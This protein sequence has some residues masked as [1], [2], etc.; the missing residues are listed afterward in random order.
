MKKLPRIK[1]IVI[2]VPA[3]SELRHEA[4]PGECS[5]SDCCCSRYEVAIE[6]PEL[7]RL[8]RLVPLA[9]RYRPDLA[10]R[11]E[12][13]RPSRRG[14]FVIDKGEERRCPF[15]YDSPQ[16]HTLC[17][18][19]SAALDAGQ[20]PFRAKPRTCALWPLT[21]TTETPRRL[22]IAGDAFEFP[23][24]RRRRAARE[25]DPSVLDLMRRVF[26]R[27]FADDAAARSLAWLR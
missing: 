18:I 22:T 17:A 16:G 8:R 19:H 23:C 4:D 24:N 15:L 14:G 2:D 25:L 13:F 10:G 1:A 5:K 12:L 9:E 3:L 20:D 6:E 27:P 7:D 21:L 11:E 26:G